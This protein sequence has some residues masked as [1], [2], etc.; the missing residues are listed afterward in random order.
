[1]GIGW[2]SRHGVVIN[3]TSFHADFKHL[4]VRNKYFKPV[5]FDVAMNFQVK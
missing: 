4:D 3:I 2:P 5:Y 1:V